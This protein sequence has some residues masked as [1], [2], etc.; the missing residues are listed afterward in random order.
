VPQYGLVAKR[1]VAFGGEAVEIQSGRILVNGIPLESGR[2]S[3][4][5]TYSDSTTSFAHENIP[6]TIPAGKV[7][8][9][10][11]NPHHSLDSRTFGAVPLEQVV[12]VD[13]KIIWPTSRRRT[14]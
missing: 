11:D 5:H 9:L 1:L 13:Y 6:Y 14:F 3:G 8:V 10:G 4:F 2:F 7:F 12:G